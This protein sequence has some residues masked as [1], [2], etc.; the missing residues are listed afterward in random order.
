VR[1]QNSPPYPHSPSAFYSTQKEF[2]KLRHSSV[3]V[4]I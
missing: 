3:L 2:D 4:E 1:P